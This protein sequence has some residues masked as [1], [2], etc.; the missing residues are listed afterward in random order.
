MREASEQ[1]LK[2]INY[3]LD[4]LRL[5][6]NLVKFELQQFDLVPLV[7]S[8]VHEYKPQTKHDV[9]LMF[10]GPQATLPQ[11][12]AD[13]KWLKRAIENLLD[14]S[15]KFTERGNITLSI[16]QDNNFI[17][18]LITDT[19]KGIPNSVRQVIFSKFAQ[20]S[21]DILTREASQGAGL[22]LY[23]SKLIMQQMHGSVQLEYSEPG[24]GSTFA[25]SLPIVKL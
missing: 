7:S 23:I 9:H 20:A 5:E 6:Q 15:F 14:N 11:V 3:F 25:I 21:Q 1:M 12:Y 19:G 24:N 2:L 13:K 10:K 16:A 22:G 8:I 18:L 4:T 17:K